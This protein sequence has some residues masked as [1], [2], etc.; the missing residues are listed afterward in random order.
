MESV[1]RLALFACSISLFALSAC[2]GI[3]PHTVA[4]DRFDYTE[5]LSESWKRHMLYNIV[6]IRYG[7][8]PIFIDVAS[9][10]NSYS[11]ATSVNAS[12][13]W[14]APISSS[15]NTL[16]VGGSGTFTD[17]P[18]ITYS[19]LTGEKFARNL[20]KPIPPPAILAL[21]EAGYPIDIVFRL[22]VNS[23]NGIRNRYGG[24]ARARLADP[25]FYPVLERMRKIQ[26]AGAV[27]LRVQKGDEMEGMVM[28]FRGKV[29]N[30]LQEDTL[31]VRK[32]L[33]LDPTASEFTVVYGAIA[34]D[35]MEIAILSRSILEIIIDLGSS[36]EVP[37]A[38][39]EEKVVN[40][41]MTEETATGATIPPLIR[42]QSSREKPG[43]AFVAVPYLDH[44][45]WIDNRDLRSK[46]LFS[47]MSFLFALTETGGKDNA[48]VITIPAR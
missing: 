10:I 19:P 29:D 34:K 33:G 16:A 20:M 48:P 17:T 22:C 7:D 41:T 35:N 37:A 15:A 6:K 13:S 8:T 36:I 25:E 31:F 27:G 4:R 24:S 45:F 2:A 23:I 42:I 9:V 30:A 43:H 5:A 46:S 38:H 3:G 26:S 12:A 47:F 44:W 21:I 40:S 18:T 1:K 32:T 39:V 11:L 14:Q 28:I